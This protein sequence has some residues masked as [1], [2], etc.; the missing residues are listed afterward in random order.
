MLN[1]FAYTCSF[2]LLA[3]ML[4][5]CRTTSV[6][7]SRRFLDDGKFNFENNDIDTSC[8]RFLAEDVLPFLV[9][10]K[11]NNESYDVVVCD[12]PTV[13]NALQDVNPKAMGRR[14]HGKQTVLSCNKQYDELVFHAAA[15]VNVGGYLVLFSNSKSL[16]KNKWL[17][18]VSL[19]LTRFADAEG[20]TTATAQSEE[21]EKQPLGGQGQGQGVR[22]GNQAEADPSD[23]PP[24]GATPGFEFVR[25]LSAA[26]DFRECPTDPMLKGIVLK[27][28]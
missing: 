26:A 20:T 15:V 19:G 10:A 13:F 21:V 22:E 14:G 4:G 2:S 27:K 5:Q 25:Y 12:P 24:P 11:S 9:N 16:R 8:H 17:E 18:M 1:L 3:A 23:E 7:I 6:D 28:L